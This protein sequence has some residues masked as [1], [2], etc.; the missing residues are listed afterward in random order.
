MGD[1]IQTTLAEQQRRK[2]IAGI[3]WRLLVHR[4][5]MRECT[6]RQKGIMHD[7]AW[8]SYATA[9]RQIHLVRELAHGR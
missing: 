9:C 2:D 4:R 6:R 3:L 8:E 5:S 7:A 1:E